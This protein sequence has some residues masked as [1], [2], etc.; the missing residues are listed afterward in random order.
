MFRL[1]VNNAEVDGLNS[2]NL[3]LNKQLFDLTEL[4]SRGVQI[5][6]NIILPRTGKNTNIFNLLSEDIIGTE[7]EVKLYND[8]ALVLSG[9]A[10]L[11]TVNTNQIKLQLTQES[12]Q[13][14]DNLKKP[15]YELDLTSSDFTF[16]RTQFNTLK[17]PSN[18]TI[19]S[20]PAVN[21]INRNSTTILDYFD[22]RSGTAGET[23]LAYARPCYKILDL[24]T[25]IIEQNGFIADL[26]EIQEIDDIVLSA[27]A[28]KFYFTDFE[29]RFQSVAVTANTS[30]DFSTGSVIKAP[31]NF[32]TLSG[33]NT[34]ITNNFAKSRYSIQG[35]IEADTVYQMFVGDEVFTL[36]SGEITVITDELDIDTGVTIEFDEDVTLVDVRI[37][38]LIDEAQYYIR[39]DVGPWPNGDV[40]LD[41]W[42]RD[43][44]GTLA[45]E[46][47]LLEDYL[48]KAAFNTPD[49]TQFEFIQELW[50]AFYLDFDFVGNIIKV[51]FNNVINKINSIKLDDVVSSGSIE[52]KEIFAQSNAFKFSND[53]RMSEFY[54]A[55]KILFDNLKLSS[56]ENTFVQLMSSASLDNR[57]TMAVSPFYIIRTANPFIYAVDVSSPNTNEGDRSTL[58]PRFYRT[59]PD[60]YSGA[61]LAEINRAGYFISS[62]PA[63][64]PTDDPIRMEFDYLYDQYYS[65]VFENINGNSSSVTTKY[66]NYLEYEEILRKKVYYVEKFGKYFLVLNIS[67]FNPNLETKIEI[68][69]F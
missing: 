46:V 42:R 29:R 1:F 32:Y 61:L 50:N 17:D 6:N 10:I 54:G 26:S 34:I 7:F 36:N 37:T 38:G 56:T 64:S 30:L 27:N 57:D 59:S 12:K 3:V 65:F 44:D 28:E 14:F 15:L 22:E 49:W 11:K 39:G 8:T 58:T 31:V 43:V 16:N 18:S 62:D 9:S 48:I 53:E 21:N 63:L 68:I 24:L 45:N 25:E 55:K 66:M 20:W 35:N 60:N 33:G 67:Q 5:S 69:G 4:D 51:T 23:E 40:G 19:W 47:P 13:F 2:N 52:A 41:G